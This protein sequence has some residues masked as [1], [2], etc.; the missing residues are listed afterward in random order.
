MITCYFGV[1]GVGK[2]TLLSKIAVNEIYRIR[3][4]KSR[5]KAVFSNFDIKGCNRIEYEDLK[6]YKMYDCLL[7]FDEMT[8]DADNREFK[9]FDKDIRDFF[10]LHRHFGVDIIYATQAYDK[11]DAKIRA[12]T[13]DLWYMSKTVV[14]LLNQFTMSQKIYRNIKINEYTGELIMGYRFCNLLERFFVKNV[15]VCFRPFYYSYFDS[16]DEGK[17][18]SR[19]E[20]QLQ[21]WSELPPGRNK[22]MS[23]LNKLSKKEKVG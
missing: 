19:D 2:S 1:P 3:R 18:A 23:F 20:L 13:A 7:L 22:V 4:G 14:P 9:K 8:L 5:Y 15:R 17:L 16:F 12:L 21:Q 11:V 10:I 6:T